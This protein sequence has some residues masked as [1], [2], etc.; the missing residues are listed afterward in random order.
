MIIIN[1]EIHTS[2]ADNTVIKNGYIMI[3]DKKIIKTGCMTELENIPE[4]VVD[5]CSKPVYPGFIDAHTHLGLFGDSLTFEGD[6]GN[7]DTDPV[8]PQLRAI[9]AVNAMDG[10][11]D[12]ALSAG[13]TTV[14]TGPGSADPIAGQIAAIKTNG[15]RIDKMVIKAPAGIKF[16][17]GE[18]PKSTYND[19]EQTPVTRMATAA[20]IREALS[21][22]QKYYRDKCNFE[23]DSES[24]DEPEND[25][26]NEALLPLFR[27]EIPAHFHV[28]RADD[29]FTA[30]RI[31]KE[32]N[33]EYVLVHATDGHLICDELLEENFCGVLSGPI[34]TDRSKP[35]LKNQSPRSPGIISSSGIKTAIITDHPETPIQYLL[36]CAAVAVREGMD[37]EE[38]IRAITCNPAEICGISQ[39]VGSIEAGKD[40]DIVI[41]SGDPLDIYNRPLMVISDGSI[42][43]D[44]FCDIV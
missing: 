25:V 41:Y 29:I 13:I 44:Y 38:A 35:E 12:E 43:K 17:L 2:D 10:Y 28:H 26:K 8:M 20:L 9:D 21:K 6:D 19:K 42:V 37:R 39:R 1:A 23:A 36:L 40:A 3:S 11:F 30:V 7:E 15:K 31:A 5:A 27:K 24:Y 34:L 4:D 16:A 33:I 32:F 18:N 14:I 22:A